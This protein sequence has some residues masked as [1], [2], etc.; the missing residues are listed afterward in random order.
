M[1]YLPDK[2]VEKIKIKLRRLIKRQSMTIK[3]F[4]EIAC[5]LHHTS[6]GIPGSRGL[7]T[8]LW[9]EMQAAKQGFIHLNKN[10]K[11]TLKDFQWMFRE[12]ANKPINVTQIVPI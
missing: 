10:L 9:A 1:I 12:I 6:M 11:Q 3:E 4:Q 8:D 2:K 7:F 5:T